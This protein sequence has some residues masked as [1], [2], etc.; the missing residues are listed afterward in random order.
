MTRPSEPE[1]T[2]TL[3]LAQANMVLGY[4]GE[5]KFRDVADIIIEL[6]NQ[7]QAQIQ[8]FQQQIAQSE[9]A[10]RPNGDARVLP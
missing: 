7:A 8:L 1:I 5:Q 4:L 2:W 9:M 6:R 3:P 10:Q